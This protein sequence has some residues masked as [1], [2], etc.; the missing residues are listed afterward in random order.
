MATLEIK[1]KLNAGEFEEACKASQKHKTLISEVQ[2]G[3]GLRVHDNV[4]VPSHIIS[5]IV[6]YRGPKNISTVAKWLLKLTKELDIEPEFLVDMI[7]VLGKGIVWR[8]NAF[9]AYKIPNVPEEHIWAYIQQKD[10]NVYTLFA[11]MLTIG[12]I[13]SSPPRT[14]DYI[15][16][17]PKTGIKTV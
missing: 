3:L 1:S 17:L 4:W 6:A 14:L 7:V 10:K 8:I 11:H 5:Y 15:S 12:K 16:Q 9:P 2:A 13:S